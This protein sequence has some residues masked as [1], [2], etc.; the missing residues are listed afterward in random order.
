VAALEVNA[1]LDRRTLIDA[2][3]LDPLDEPEPDLSGHRAG[4]HCVVALQHAGRDVGS[5]GSVK[6]GRDLGDRLR[7]ERTPLVLELRQR[8]SSP[9]SP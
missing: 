9:Q 7:I 8:R 4:A 2:G 5:L 6:L 1:A 3:T